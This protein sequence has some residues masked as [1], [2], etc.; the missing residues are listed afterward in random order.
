MRARQIDLSSAV[1]LPSNTFD[2]RGMRVDEGLDALSEFLDQCLLRH[3]DS[4]FILHGHGTGALKK[5]VR[6][7]L[8]SSAHIDR[9]ARANEDQGGDA[10]TVVALKSS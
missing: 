9:W 4:A 7:W 3:H 6:D 8:P 2:M 5:A 10:F 1:K